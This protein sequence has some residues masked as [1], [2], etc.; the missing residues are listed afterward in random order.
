MAAVLACPQGS[1]L[2]HNSASALWGIDDREREVVV[3]IPAGTRVRRKDIRIHCRKLG[4]RDRARRT[5]IPVTSVAR[6]L[7][8]LA[9]IADPSRL[10]AAVSAADRLEL[11]DP[12]SLRAQLS[13]RFGVPGAPALRELLDREAFSLTDSELE[14][15]FLRLVRG[16]GLPSPRTQVPMLGFRL[17]FYWPEM[18]LVVETDGLRY[19]RTAAQQAK[20]RGRDQ[21]L[22][23]RGLVVLRFTHRQVVREGV[24]VAATLAEVMRTRIRAA[25]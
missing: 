11:I 4:P 12:E 2:S 20:D 25:A 17:D 21:A 6:T 9:T 19:H 7:T 1:V 23:T 24:S 10:E 18:G 8:D 5:R 13:E 16:A 22:A 14:R 15:A 3:T